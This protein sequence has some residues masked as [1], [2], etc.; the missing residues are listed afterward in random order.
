M[1]NHPPP[2]VVAANPALVAMCK[3]ESDR[4]GSL[5]K[6]GRVHQAYS[7]HQVDHN[8]PRKT[9]IPQTTRCRNGFCRSGHRSAAVL[10][11]QSYDEEETHR[12]SEGPEQ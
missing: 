8:V 10:A 11:R 6:R 1:Y 9:S 3:T 4:R 5:A 12:P 2:A 7:S